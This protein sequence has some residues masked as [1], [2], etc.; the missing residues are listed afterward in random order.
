[1]R[2]ECDRMSAEGPEEVE[3]TLV[4]PGGLRVR[5]RWA[6]QFQVTETTQLRHGA[7]APRA[8]VGGAGTMA[9]GWD[10]EVAVIGGGPGGSSAAAHLARKGHRVLLLERDTFPRFHIGESQVPWSNE[11][12]GALGCAEAMSAAGFV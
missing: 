12:F 10:Y 4:F 1:M 11:V 8:G 2:D 3:Y 7:P 5:T 6:F 9:R